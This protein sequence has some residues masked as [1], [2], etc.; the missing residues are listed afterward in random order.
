MFMVVA[1][2]NAVTVVAFVLNKVK[3]ALEVIKDVRKVGEVLNTLTP[4]PVS[5]VRAVS[6]CADVNDPNTAALPTDVICP[7]RLAFVALFPF[8]F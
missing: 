7:V 6:N 3:V 5:S 8:S 4:D 1:D 2:P